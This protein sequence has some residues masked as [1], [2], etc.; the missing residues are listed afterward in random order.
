MPVLTGY[1]LSGLPLTITVGGVQAGPLV[2]IGKV[3]QSAGIV[4]VN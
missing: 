3:Y 1:S 2:Y 4:W